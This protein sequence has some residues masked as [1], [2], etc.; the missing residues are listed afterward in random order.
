MTSTSPNCPCCDPTSSIEQYQPFIS[1]HQ[2]SRICVLDDK[3]AIRKSFKC[4]MI[5]AES[6][7]NISRLINLPMEVFQRTLIYLDIQSLVNLRRSSQ[8]CRLAVSSLLEWQEVSDN[9]PEALRAILVT[10]MGSHILLL[11]LHYALTN[12]ECEFC[13]ENSDHPA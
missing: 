11:Q 3:T 13:P 1:P 10:G 6:A 7:N 8:Y 5:Q 9:A 4:P 12:P 2:L